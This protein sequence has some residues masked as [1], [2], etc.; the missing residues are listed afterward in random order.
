[1]YNIHP[2]QSTFGGFKLHLGRFGVTLHLIFSYIIGVHIKPH[3]MVF[4]ESLFNYH[5]INKIIN[6]KLEENYTIISKVDPHQSVG[7]RIVLAKE[8]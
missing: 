5:C 4:Q 7:N 3:F 1:M 8:K 6:L 2:H